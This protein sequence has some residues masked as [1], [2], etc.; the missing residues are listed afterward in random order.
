MSAFALAACPSGGDGN[1]A[2]SKVDVSDGT[3][4]GA[5][6]GSGDVDPADSDVVGP[7]ADADG[8]TKTDGDCID[9]DVQP[10]GDVDADIPDGDADAEVDTKDIIPDDGGG[11]ELPDDG[12]GPGPDADADVP[13]DVPLACEPNPCTD[14][15]PTECNGNAN[16][17]IYE[18]TGTCTVDDAGEVLCDYKVIAN[19][20][21]NDGD[22]CTKDTCLAGIGCVHQFDD[23]LDPSCK[24]VSP[25]DNVVCNDTAPCTFDSCNQLTGI[26]K[27]RVPQLR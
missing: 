14:P 15:P 9:C 18:P 2:D 4:D 7:D 5:G 17:I 1:E 20:D 27:F 12:G 22:L 19:E 16:S 10:D 3:G 8:D 26:C 13:I 23:A 21:C 25:C 24:V 11:T 6:D